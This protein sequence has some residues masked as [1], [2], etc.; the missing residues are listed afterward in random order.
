MF[1]VRIRTKRFLRKPKEE[2]FRGYWKTE[3]EVRKVVS[4]YK[5]NSEIIRIKKIEFKELLPIPCPRCGRTDLH[6]HIRIPKTSEV[7]KEIAKE[8]IR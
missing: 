3:E 1:E 5:P 4:K 6:T 2:T 7:L 8:K